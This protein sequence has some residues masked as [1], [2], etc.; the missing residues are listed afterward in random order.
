[1]GAVEFY[2]MISRDRR[3]PPP[4]WA[5]FVEVGLLFLH[6]FLSLFIFVFFLL[7]GSAV[8]HPSPKFWFG[9]GPFK[10]RVNHVLLSE[11]DTLSPPDSL[12][13]HP[14]IP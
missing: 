1:M 14:L 13:T 6:L 11:L 7:I 8:Q 9:T 2:A 12:S 3:C 4:P 10:C 5:T